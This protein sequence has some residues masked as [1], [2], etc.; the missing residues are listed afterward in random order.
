MIESITLR[1]LNLFD[2]VLNQTC[3]DVNKEKF[4]SF[5]TNSKQDNV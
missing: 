1:H 2:T 3:W 5:K 4:H